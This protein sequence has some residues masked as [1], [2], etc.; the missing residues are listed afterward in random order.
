MAKSSSGK[1]GMTVSNELVNENKARIGKLR[2]QMRD[3]EKEIER[4]ES[5]R[6][7]DADMAT[8]KEISDIKQKFKKEL[9]NN[10]KFKRMSWK[11]F[12]ETDDYFIYALN[13][14]AY[15]H[16]CVDGTSDWVKVAVKNGTTLE[17]LETNA[18]RMRVAR[19]EREERAKRKKR[20]AIMELENKSNK[21]GRKTTEDS[22]GSKA[23]LEE[24]LG[25]G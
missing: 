17:Q 13:K 22:D 19:W 20:K 21:K 8:W 1:D 25:N 23:S 15:T 6:Q 12:S 5:T 16:R 2:Q 18:T 10:T 7:R 3:A 11:K 24:H 9:A 4:L 14:G